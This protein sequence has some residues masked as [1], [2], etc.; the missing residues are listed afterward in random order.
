MGCQCPKDN[1]P[2]NGQSVSHYDYDDADDSFSLCL[3]SS[4]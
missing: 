1:S 2:T 3:N 4:S